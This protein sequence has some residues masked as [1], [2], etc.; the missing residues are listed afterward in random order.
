MESKVRAMDQLNYTEFILS[1]SNL[2]THA[3]G[4]Q[5]V[6][7]SEISRRLV[8]MESKSGSSNIFKRKAPKTK[9]R[10]LGKLVMKTQSG[11]SIPLRNTHLSLI[12]EYFDVIDELCLVNFII[13]NPITIK[14]LRINKNT[15]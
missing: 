12:A 11:W 8:P 10:R 13:D 9:N 15:L 14:D 3:F 2:F 4:L 7:F 5:C 1:L 6:I